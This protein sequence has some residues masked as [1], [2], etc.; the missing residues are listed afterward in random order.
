MNCIQ[1]PIK[2][3]LLPSSSSLYF[4]RT[5][6]E[7]FCAQQ[8]MV[9]ATPGTG[10][11]SKEENQ[12]LLPIVTKKCGHTFEIVTSTIVYLR[13]KNKSSAC[14][15]NSGIRTLSFDAPGKHSYLNRS[16]KIHLLTFSC[17]LLGTN[18]NTMKWI[19]R[20]NQDVES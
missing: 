4:E 13:Q 1:W 9:V 10:V 19:K 15:M 14:E 17:S 20:K 12:R 6:Q 11:E 16:G 18:A 3:L 5:Q 2:L 7:S 8:E